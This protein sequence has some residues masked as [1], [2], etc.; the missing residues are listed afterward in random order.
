MIVLPNWKHSFARRRRS[1]ESSLPLDQRM[2]AELHSG[3]LL[4]PE[5]PANLP[6]CRTA[7]FE[8]QIIRAGQEWTHVPAPKR[9]PVGME[10]ICNS[11]HLFGRLNLSGNRTLHSIFCVVLGYL[12]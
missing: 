8:V 10:F 5:F 4:K 11:P 3:A 12:R 9:D 7:L 6:Q 1:L 2:A